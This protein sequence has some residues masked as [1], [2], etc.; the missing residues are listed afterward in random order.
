MG[1]PCDSWRNSPI[2][3]AA[4]LVSRLFV[5]FQNKEDAPPGKRHNAWRTERL[6]ARLLDPKSPELSSNKVLGISR[7]SEDR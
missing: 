5:T 7:V 6:P 1:S 3:L 4:I 2:E